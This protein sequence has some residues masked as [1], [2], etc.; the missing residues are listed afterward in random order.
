MDRSEN[1]LAWCREHQVVLRWLTED[2][3]K[4][5]RASFHLGDDVIVSVVTVADESQ[6]L[7][8]AVAELAGAA[9]ARSR[10]STLRLVRS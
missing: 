10:R 4:K 6:G 7:I 5:L 1:A 9:A 2:G 3:E 8:D